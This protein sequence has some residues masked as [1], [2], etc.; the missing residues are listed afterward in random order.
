MQRAAVLLS[1]DLLSVDHATDAVVQRVLCEEFGGCTL[2]MI[3]HRLSSIL[4][5]NCVAVLERGELVEC[6]P[7]GGLLSWESKFKRLVDAQS[8]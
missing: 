7:S 4:D 5:F 1:T 6:G 8:Y 2:I 3:A